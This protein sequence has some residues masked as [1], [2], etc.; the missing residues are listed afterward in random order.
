M[1]HYAPLNESIV[2]WFWNVMNGFGL[3]GNWYSKCCFTSKLCS[4]VLQ[5]WCKPK[6]EFWCKYIKPNNYKKHYLTYAL[7]QA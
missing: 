7:W 1:E 4:E 6:I 2:F 5:T 3:A